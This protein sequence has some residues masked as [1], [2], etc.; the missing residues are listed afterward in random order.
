MGVPFAVQE[1]GTLVYLNHQWVDY[2]DERVLYEC[3][4]SKE[5]FEACRAT[6]SMTSNAH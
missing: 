4:Q 5:A 2:S 1:P 3:Y 6:H